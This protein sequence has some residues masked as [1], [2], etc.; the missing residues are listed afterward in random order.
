VILYFYEK[1]VNDQKMETS[2]YRF[3]K[4]INYFFPLIKLII[5]S[6]PLQFKGAKVE[7]LVIIGK[8]KLTGT[9]NKLHI[10]DYTSLG[11]CHIALH[12]KVTID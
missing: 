7:K 9:I 11:R 1:I 2:D 4:K 3:S 6:I 8:V 12:D 10:S 5:K